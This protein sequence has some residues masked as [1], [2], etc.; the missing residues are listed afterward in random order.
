MSVVGLGEKEIAPEDIREERMSI[1]MLC[2]HFVSL[3]KQCEKCSCVMTIKT[4]II[5]SACPIGKW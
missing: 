1:C 2:E 4:A 5:D 3:T